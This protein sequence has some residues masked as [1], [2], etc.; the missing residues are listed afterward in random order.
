MKMVIRLFIATYQ[1]SKLYPFVKAAC[2]TVGN[3]NLVE[4]NYTDENSL[5]KLFDY[6]KE[7]FGNTDFVMNDWASYLCRWWI[8]F[9]GLILVI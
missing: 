2:D 7:K 8:F 9:N 1:S 6:V 4:F 5:E 3:I